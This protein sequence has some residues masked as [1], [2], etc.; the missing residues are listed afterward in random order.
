M[1]DLENDH[2]DAEGRWYNPYSGF[3]EGGLDPHIPKGSIADLKPDTTLDEYRAIKPRNIEPTT[4]SEFA[5]D[6]LVPRS[7]GR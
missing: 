6:K 2:Y 1:A 7:H 5:R 3:H 4:I